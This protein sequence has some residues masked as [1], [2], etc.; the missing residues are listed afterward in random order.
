MM[1]LNGSAFGHH[2]PPSPTELDLPA[3]KAWSAQAPRGGVDIACERGALWIT[4]EG[5]PEDHVVVA[6]AHFKAAHGRV[7]A[8]ALEPARMAIT[9]TH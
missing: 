8:L 4:V 6:P 2:G 5:D 9:T 7:A 1:T 3:G